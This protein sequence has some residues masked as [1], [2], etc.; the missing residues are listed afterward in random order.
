MNRM[1][2]QNL[3]NIKDRFERETGASL[4]K[5]PAVV[6]RG[7]LL[8]LASVL[9]VGLLLT[10]FAV[11]LFSPLDGDELCLDGSYLGDGIVSVRVENR[12][13]KVLTFTDARLY[14]WN[15]GKVEMVP[16]GKVA[17][18]GTRVEPNGEGVLTVD[19]S[20]AYDID[21]L[22]STTPGKPKQ[23]WYYLL[24]TNQSFL[25][26]HDWIC[27]FSF[28]EEA[29]METEPAWTPAGAEQNLEGV[30]EELRFY[31]AQ[32]YFDV[33]PAFNE[34]HFTYQQRVEE[35]LMR[36][37][38]TL[39]YPVNPAFIL[40]EEQPDNT[41]HRYSSLDGYKRMVGSRF[42]GEV[43]DAVFQIS[44]ILPE[45]VTG[46]NTVPLVFFA[47][48]ESESVAE[49]EAYTFL[50]GRILPFAELEPNRVFQGEGYTVYDVTDLYYSDLEAYLKD[51]T[52][53]VD[54]PTLGEME[55]IRDDYR[56]P[57]NL[58]FSFPAGQE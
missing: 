32:S 9:A 51:L 16:G 12:S 52:G 17:L 15:D 28:G 44:G 39:V 36:T 34:Q 19:L 5:E 47:V 46:E 56:N 49:A 27:S 11:P 2:R 58:T 24:L 33:L 14:S 38:G 10:A 53:G 42:S 7:K 8:F 54:A 31:F 21:F 13:D 6:P 50:Y 57:D 55:A 18:T 20:G 45:T 43:S 25:F 4:Q 35:L 23:S 22:E 29:A 26:G 1:T 40:E 3:N 48:F 41:S 30:P 37:P